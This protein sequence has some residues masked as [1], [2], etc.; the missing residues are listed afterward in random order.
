LTFC[1]DVDAGR[2]DALVPR[3]ERAAARTEPFDVTLDGPGRFGHRVLFAT[4]DG[5][6]PALRRLAERTA[7][8][9][10]RVGVEVPQERYRPH[11]RG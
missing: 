4:V 8:A 9:A 5:D 7:A 3:L 11:A 6:R 2:F 10:R 1:G